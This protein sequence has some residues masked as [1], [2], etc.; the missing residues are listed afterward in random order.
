MARD[1]LE[2][3]RDYFCCEQVTGKAV[4]GSLRV[5]DERIQVRLVSFDDFFFVDR[6]TEYLP[7]RLEDNSYASLHHAFFG[8]PGSS[9]SRTQT[10]HSQT[11]SANTLIH[12]PDEWKPEDPILHVTFEL[13]RAEELLRYDPKIKEL[14]SKPRWSDVET[15]AFT[16]DLPD[17]TVRLGYRSTYAMTSDRVSVESPVIAVDFTNPRSIKNYL[18]DIQAIVRF[19]SLIL[20]IQ[21]EPENIRIRRLSNEDMRAQ[22]EKH[23]YLGD[24]SV[25]QMWFRKSSAADNGA[26]VHLAFAALF[27]EEEMQAFSACLRMW[28]QR[29]PEWARSNALMM[30]C[31]HLQDEISAERLLAAC[32]WLEEIP[33]ARAVQ[34]T[35]DSVIQSIT[36]AALDAAD[37]Q[38]QDLLKSRIPQAIARLK[39]ESHRER[40]D[41][42][43]KNLAE[44]YGSGVTDDD[45]SSHLIAALRDFRGKV[46]HGHYE[47]KDDNEYQRFIKATFAVESLCLLLTCFDM[48]LT[49]DGVR[50]IKLNPLVEHYRYSRID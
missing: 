35:D 14:E 2:K 41:R 12:G 46:A 3:D 47:P 29:T 32:K 17:L 28:L 10:T 25:T 19:I 7:L 11:V 23:S 8:G 48:P 33:T 45:M 20:G 6:N 1:G 30:D 36:D 4:C 49:D 40:F 21:M 39:L 26:R 44:R 50:R 13:P 38:G 43:V 22:I 9:N 34:V 16:V 27:D 24:H 42:L 18:D 15:Y 31:L 37:E 5:T